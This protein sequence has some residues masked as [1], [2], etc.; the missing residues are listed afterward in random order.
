[1]KLRTV[2]GASLLVAIFVGLVQPG[3]AAA[4]ALESAVIKGKKDEVHGTGAWSADG[5]REYVAF[6]RRNLDTGWEQAYLRTRWSG[7]S[8]TVRVNKSGTADIGGFF[9]KRLLFAQAAGEGDWDIWVFNPATEK[10][11][12]LNKA[13]TGKDEALPTRSGRY[14]L[15]NRNDGENG[16][17]TSVVLR[18]LR[19]SENAEIVLAKTTT[20]DAF[21]YA[22][23]VRGN[24][25]VW[26]VC[27]PTCGVYT[28]DIAGQ[29]T[30][31]V[32][33]PADDPEVF[34]FDASVTKDGVVYLMRPT[35]DTCAAPSEL[36]RYG[37]SDPPEGTVVAEVPAGRFTTLT[38][39]RFNPGG[40]VDIF[41][42]RG[43]CSTFH[44]DIYRVR[45][46]P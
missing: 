7:G 22:G 19:A 11:Y 46:T 15:F 9:G 18:D 40:T 27:D 25:A 43:S 3:E 6:T 4:L 20:P 28:R 17:R 13:S 1:M 21:A 32:P 10:R 38:Y 8:D 26:T 16:F 33:K 29:V 5:K 44:S 41:Y 42:S 36:V 2:S 31:E 24:W 39:T 23:Q 12:R 14:L 35:G 34:Q 37:D 30:A 45:D